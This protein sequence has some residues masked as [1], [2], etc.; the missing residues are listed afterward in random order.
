MRRAI[1]SGWFA[2][3]ILNLPHRDFL[4]PG[5]VATGK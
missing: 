3:A 4:P 5:R 1:P 2:G